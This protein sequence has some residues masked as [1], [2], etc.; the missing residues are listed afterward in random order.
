MV[1]W[2]HG[3]LHFIAGNHDIYY[4]NTLEVN[5]YK[6]LRTRAQRK[7]LYV[8]D[9]WPSA[10]F[11]GYDIAMIPWITAETYADTMNFIKNT[12]PGCDGTF[13]DKGI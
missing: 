6:E 12:T 3:C 13:G 11:Q 10:N 2:I 4:K 8:H 9:R 7:C 5:C 1:L